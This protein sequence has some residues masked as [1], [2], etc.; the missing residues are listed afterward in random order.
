M[1]EF[2]KDDR[3]ELVHV[4]GKP[5]HYREKSSHGKGPISEENANY[6]RTSRPI[7][8]DT[9]MNAA[10]KPANQQSSP[11]AEVSEVK[12]LDSSPTEMSD[13]PSN[14]QLT[15]TDS[16]QS[17]DFVDLTRVPE[18]TTPNLTQPYGNRLIPQIMD[19]LAATDPQRIVFS[20]AKLHR[21][22]LELQHISAQSFTR[23]VDK[24]AWWLRGQVGTQ[25]TI[26]P[27][28]YIGPRE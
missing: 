5:S 27:V 23:A 8:K 9:Y 24:T 15:P 10:V 22:V 7:N 6:L 1:G 2:V 3:L 28:A 20:L 11:R 4:N 17:V 16:D 19:E 25:S 13:T 26:R 21:G 12:M 18:G 14:G